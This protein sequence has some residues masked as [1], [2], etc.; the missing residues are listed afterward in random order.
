MVIAIRRGH[1]CARFDVATSSARSDASEMAVAGGV[2]ETMSAV[3]PRGCGRRSAS[4]RGGLR[5]RRPNTMSVQGQ[6]WAKRL[7]HR[8]YGRSGASRKRRLGERPAIEAKQL[9]RAGHPPFE[10][11]S[12]AGAKRKCHWPRSVGEVVA[13]RLTMRCRRT[14]QTV[15]DFARGRAKSPPVCHA[16]ERKR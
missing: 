12:A 9:R 16:A 2:V 6:R 7:R 14:W 1:S 15:S 10:G 5:L 3:A 8:P 11:N 13:R 4:L